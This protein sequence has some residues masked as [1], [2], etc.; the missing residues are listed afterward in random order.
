MNRL[1]K[2]EGLPYD[3]IT[4][5]V[6]RGFS[7]AKN[8]MIRKPEGQG[9]DPASRGFSLANKPNVGRGFSPA[10]NMMIRKPEGQ[11]HD[12]ASRGFSPANKP[13]VGR[14]FSPAKT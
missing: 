8:M 5:F 4:S 2:P 9:H 11:G 3:K 7:P 10:K 13:N 1:R 12:P 14:G 6:G